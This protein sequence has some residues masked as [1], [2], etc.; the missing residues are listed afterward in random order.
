MN[1]RNDWRVVLMQMGNRRT[2]SAPASSISAL[3]EKEKMVLK[4]PTILCNRILTAT[5]PEPLRLAWD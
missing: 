4:C 5:S 3:V 2:N 1:D